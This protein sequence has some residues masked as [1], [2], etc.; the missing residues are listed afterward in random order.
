[1]G[2]GRAL[3]AQIDT[4]DK[5]ETIEHAIGKNIKRSKNAVHNNLQRKKSPKKKTTL[6]SSEI[7]TENSTGFG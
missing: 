4:L 1:M 3:K 6:T 7:E 2:R 5:H